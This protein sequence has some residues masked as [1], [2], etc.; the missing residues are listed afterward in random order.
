MKKIDYNKYADTLMPTTEELFK[1]LE[2]LKEEAIYML[3]NPYHDEVF[4][5]DLH[6]LR[7]A[8]SILQDILE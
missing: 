5:K 7:I 8:I 3:K 1:Q 6:A 4:E 2:S